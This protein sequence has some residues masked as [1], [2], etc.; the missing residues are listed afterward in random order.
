MAQ[1]KSNQPG[2]SEQSR[3]EQ[4]RGGQSRSETN[5]GGNKGG[6]KASEQGRTQPDKTS[7]RGQQG[8]DEDR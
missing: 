5:R 3:T 1:Q 2:Q 6:G 4:G 8:Q 7:D